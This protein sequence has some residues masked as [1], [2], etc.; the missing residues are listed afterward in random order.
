MRKPFLLLAA[1][2]ASSAAIAEDGL[3]DTA[4]VMTA[5]DEHPSVVAARART[6]AARAEARALAKGAHEFTLTGTFS[7]RTIDREGQFSEYDAL[8]TRPVRLPG[9]AS[10]DRT[11]GRLGIDAAEN[12]AEDA[13]H[14]AA[15]TLMQS[16]W[17]W[18][19]AAHEANIDREVVKNAERV[20]GAVRRRE[21]LGDASLLEVNQAEAALGGARVAA[22]QSA[23]R[24]ATAKTR[25]AAQFPALPLPQSAPEAPSPVLPSAG[26]EPYRDQILAHSHEIAAAAAEA[27]RSESVAERVRRDR[28][29][30]PSVG[31][32]V[33]SERGGMERGAGLVLSVPFGGGHR[34]A[35]ADRVAAE[36]SAAQAELQAV[37]Y[38]IRETADTDLAEAEYRYASWQRAREGL[39]AQVAALTKQRRGYD[40]G[41][42]D[43]SDLLYAERQ[44][45]DAFRIEG[46]TRVEA[47]RAITKLKIDSHELWLRD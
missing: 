30:D 4:V 8:L 41:E 33:F 3:P 17:D 6:D 36:S 20:L 12:R 21:S 13:K 1:L 43:L 39:A 45:G 11:I 24:E 15:L 14:Q 37:R 25:L 32:R 26:L 22:Q 2:L 10:L 5:L 34:S 18:V 46:Q 31:L 28:I 35:L 19:A 44:V 27:S 42:V 40:A 23:G 16:W 9:K 29:A 47:L 7:R 38:N